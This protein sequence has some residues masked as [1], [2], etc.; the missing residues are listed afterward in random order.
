MLFA[1]SY[2]FRYAYN[3]TKGE[4]IME[5]NCCNIAVHECIKKKAY[6][7]WEKD[8]RKPGRDLRYW[9]IAERVLRVWAK[10]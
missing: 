8:G 6:E 9:L 1:G 4:N 10:E 7:L 5:H 2:I 3:E